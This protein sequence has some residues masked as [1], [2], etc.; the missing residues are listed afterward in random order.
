MALEP[1]PRA[2]YGRD[3][4]PTPCTSGSCQEADI[5]RPLRKTDY[6][7][8]EFAVRDPEGNLWSFGD[9][10]GEPAPE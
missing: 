8:H 9:Y 1:E 5:V 7:A 2:A 6:G 3:R 10:T 4:D